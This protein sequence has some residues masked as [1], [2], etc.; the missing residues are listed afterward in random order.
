MSVDCLKM[1]KFF[2]MMLLKTAS[3]AN[4]TCS[5]EGLDYS[6]GHI[7]PDLISSNGDQYIT[8]KD[9]ATDL[10]L[11]WNQTKSTLEIFS[12][13]TTP[14]NAKPSFLMMNWNTPI[15]FFQRDTKT[16]GGFMASLLG[17][18]GN[19]RIKCTG[20]PAF[21]T[22]NAVS[23]IIDAKQ[24][25]LE[26][27]KD[28]D[29]H[30]NNLQKA[31]QENALNDAITLLNTLKNNASQAENEANKANAA[32]KQAVAAAKNDSQFEAL[33][34]KAKADLDATKDAANHTQQS[35][36]SSQQHFD[37]EKD[38]Q[39][40]ETLLK[41]VQNSLDQSNDALT[42]MNAL[43]Q[44][45][46][47][48]DPQ[49]LL[50]ALM[51]LLQRAQDADKDILGIREKIKS[52][53]NLQI[54]DPFMNAQNTSQNNLAQMQNYLN[55]LMSSLYQNIPSD[56]Q[57]LF[58]D[59]YLNL[60]QLA[61]NVAQE[62]LL[63]AQAFPDLYA[64]DQ[65][66]LN[67]LMQQFFNNMNQVNS[68]GANAEYL[69]NQAGQLGMNPEIIKGGLQNLQNIA[70]SM[71]RLFPLQQQM[72]AAAHQIRKKGDTQNIDHQNVL[73]LLQNMKDKL[74]NIQNLRAQLSLPN[75]ND[76][77]ILQ[78][79]LALL[80][81]KKNDS[82][83]A[84]QDLMDFYALLSPYNSFK[85]SVAEGRKA[86]DIAEQFIQEIR[87][88]KETVEQNLN[89]ASALQNEKNVASDAMNRLMNAF[90]SFD[91]LKNLAQSG[92]NPLY[93]LEKL[94]DA[95]ENAA[96]QMTEMQMIF[97]QT[98]PLL[99]QDQ[100]EI[101]E[102]LDRM[103]KILAD[104]RDKMKDI[105]D[106][107]II[108]TLLQKLTPEEKQSLMNDYLMSLDPLFADAHEK[109]G[110]IEKK[111]EDLDQ[112]MKEMSVGKIDKI[113]KDIMPWNAAIQS[114]L[115]KSSLLKNTMQ[116]IV[117]SDHRNNLQNAMD[118]KKDAFLKL[119]QLNKNNNDFIHQ[120]FNGQAKAKH[121]TDALMHKFRDVSSA[122]KAVT[123]GA[124]ELAELKDLLGNLP[125]IDQLERIA[126][127][128][129]NTQWG[130]D[131][132]L[133]A[134]INN[135]DDDLSKFVVMAQNLIKSPENM[136]SQIDQLLQTLEKMKMD[137]NQAAPSEKNT[138]YD[139]IQRVLTDAKNIYA[140]AKKDFDIMRDSLSPDMKALLDQHIHDEMARKR[141]L[142]NPCQNNCRVVLNN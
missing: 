69:Y 111:K 49:T 62:A 109:W 110:D 73:I 77:K 26:F 27:Q 89:N 127:A 128:F 7:P 121:Y 97:D 134:M 18:T 108:R 92:K 87:T 100:P 98:A 114:A 14:H 3:Y 140:Q 52:L 71:Q 95:Q 48:I 113:L 94:R 99:S 63:N 126:K 41:N 33:L 9:P 119:D 101:Q 117:D 13:G 133:Q 106:Q 10:L 83:K 32:Y 112:A 115:A 107:E 88:L 11:A 91:A 102:I 58:S 59:Y 54:I 44:N 53:N 75:T 81:V 46:E 55:S 141:N 31:L 47:G 105:N 56:Q 6:S 129:S 122:F 132:A 24:R 34:S 103:K 138:L 64:R 84:F 37:Q 65:Q 116:Q 137:A 139:S 38:N 36:G 42:Q 8:S 22:A 4:V 123:E 23:S 43:L 21:D 135:P 86:V 60:A 124:Q 2:L 28:N 78:E 61:L 20:S 15:S 70:A 142:E 104:A 19:V 67:S 40:A 25:V 79:F 66:N 74:Q 125:Q 76:P 120:L 130:L 118:S 131:K 72:L 16:P 96:D 93:I 50:N 80:S 82:Q 29:A 90:N 35:Y 39:F 30:S 51:G 57:P 85:E 12:P 45:T 5:I 68:Y 1:Q 17:V 136:S